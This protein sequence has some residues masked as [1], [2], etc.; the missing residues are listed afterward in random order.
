MFVRRAFVM[1]F[2]ALI[3]PFSGCTS[4]FSAGGADGVTAKALLETA[5]GASGM[6]DEGSLLSVF[7]LETSSGETL[8]ERSPPAWLQPFLN[9]SDSDIGDGRAHAWGYYFG[10]AMDGMEMEGGD[11]HAHAGGGNVIVV[12]S[13]DQKTVY[14]GSVPADFPISPAGPLGSNW[15][16]DSDTAASTA[17]DGELDAIIDDADAHVFS[18]LALRI[19]LPPAWMFEAGTASAQDGDTKAVDARDGLKIRLGTRDPFAPIKTETGEVSG[20]ATPQGVSS[21][22]SIELPSH[23]QI[24]FFLE[25][26]GGTGGGMT[27][28]G[29]QVDF[30]AKGPGGQEF[31]FH[32]DGGGGTQQAWHQFDAP[33]PGDW[34]LEAK[35]VNDAGGQAESQAFTVHWCALGA[36][37]C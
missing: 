11:G 9:V 19:D 26:S 22:F 23:R 32:W 37:R 12:V 10:M 6:G 16:V 31:P 21:T 5:E 7:T 17:R 33:N 15:T 30:L 3:L 36:T 13:S 2:A 14:K 27:P 29:A 20:S 35:L 8:K 24:E 1:V 25:V 28:T 18:S 34:T 4:P